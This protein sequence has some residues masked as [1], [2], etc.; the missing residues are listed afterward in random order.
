MKLKDI[1]CVI[2]VVQGFTIGIPVDSQQ[3]RC[4]NVFSQN[5][6]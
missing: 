4:M 2:L 1:I 5:N 6:N 3:D